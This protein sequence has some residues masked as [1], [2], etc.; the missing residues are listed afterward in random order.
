MT[1][2][3]DLTLDPKIIEK[4]NRM[5]TWKHLNYEKH[6]IAKYSTVKSWTV[7][8]ENG[9]EID[10]KVCSSNTDEPLWCEAVLFFNGS[11]CCCSEVEGS[12]DGTWDFEYEN[13]EFVLVVKE[14]ANETLD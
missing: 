10:L 13:E 14:K 7:D 8:F 3:K 1:Y 6:G 5:L 4:F 12:L 2:E 11:E 9:F